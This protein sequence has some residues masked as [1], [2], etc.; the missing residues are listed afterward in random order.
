MFTLHTSKIPKDLLAITRAGVQFYTSTYMKPRTCERIDEVKIMFR[1]FKEEMIA[2]VDFE[3]VDPFLPTEFQ[4]IFNQDCS[5]MPIRDYMMTLFH[6]LTHVNQYATGKLRDRPN[7]ITI[8]D[9]QRY[10]HSTMNYYD[11]PWEI[12]ANGLEQSSY[13][14]FVE[15]NPQFDLQRFKPSYDGRSMSDW[16][17]FVKQQVTIAAKSMT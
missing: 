11:M 4:V 17:P 13:G 6:E 14:K 16:K 3:P 5:D 15:V 7:D 2:Y 1:S 9:K 10:V 12:E 8:W